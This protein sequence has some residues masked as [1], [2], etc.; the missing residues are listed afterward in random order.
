MKRLTILLAV[1]A[2]CVAIE[3][4]IRDKATFA[5]MYVVDPPS[6]YERLFSRTTSD[7]EMVVADYATPSAKAPEPGTFVFMF[8]GIVGI[9]VRFVRKSFDRLKRMMDLALSV[10][11]LTFCLPILA[12]IALL[13][14]LTSPGPIVY[15]QRRVG[16]DG[17]VFRIYKLRTMRTDAEKHSGAVWA[18]ERDPRITPIGRIL[19]KSHFDEVLQFYNVLRGDMSIVGPRPERPEIVTDLLQ[20]IHD[21]DRRLTVKPGI[22]GLSQVRWSYDSTLE[23]V[24]RKVKYDLLYI[25]KMCLLVDVRIMAR[26][27]LVMATG[28]GAH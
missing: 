7:P 9:I 10:V 8:G 12:F 16:K 15:T 2:A 19:R 17:N 14:K 26:T 22:T 4:S 20:K 13:I 21:Y 5:I 25:K 18:S 23:D 27:F 1:F 28:K 6:S 3:P 24:K 11:A